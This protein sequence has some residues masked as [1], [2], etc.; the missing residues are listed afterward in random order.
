M[1]LEIGSI[2]GGTVKKVT[3]YGAFVELE[4]GETGLV[5]I[6][7]ID[8][9]YVKSVTDFVHEEDGVKVKVLA[10][11]SDGKIDL[12]IK[13]AGGETRARASNEPYMPPGGRATVGR[14]GNP[15]FERMMKQ[16]R[17][18]SEEKLGDVRRH[19]DGKRPK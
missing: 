16:F 3:N 14:S 5:H 7:E 11:K 9:S 13:Q 2:V 18:A 10:V 4:T 6:S 17:R 15:G 19:R 8:N 12:S 1:A